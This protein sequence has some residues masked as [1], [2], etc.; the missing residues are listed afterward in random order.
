MSQLKLTGFLVPKQLPTKCSS[1]ETL[2]SHP[3]NKDYTFDPTTKTFVNRRTKTRWGGSLKRLCRKF[4]PGYVAPERAFNGS[5]SKELGKKIH[6]HV[7]HQVNCKNTPQRCSCDVKTCRLNARA[8]AL[9][10][11]LDKQE[12]I[13]LVR[14]EVPVV[15]EQGQ[16]G[17]LLDLVGV[18]R[19][20][21][22]TVLISIKTGYRGAHCDRQVIAR[23]EAPFD[24]WSDCP[25]NHHRLQLLVEYLICQ[26]EYGMQF[27]EA[28]LIYS[29]DDTQEP[30]V[31]YPLKKLGPMLSRAFYERLCITNKD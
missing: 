27:D 18:R 4:Y 23:M 24:Q 11:M 7:Q 22:A 14:A 20:S 6:R 9:L 10:T 5:S 8:R 3:R 2:M 12:D 21:G 16:F 26:H 1:L 31:K 15:S 13:E 25:S 17:T 19:K 28:L 29:K 30:T